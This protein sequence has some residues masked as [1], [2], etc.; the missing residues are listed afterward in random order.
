MSEDGRGDNV[1]FGRGMV[2][3]RGDEGGG[4]LNVNVDGR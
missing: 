1:G 2:G 3:I 4:S